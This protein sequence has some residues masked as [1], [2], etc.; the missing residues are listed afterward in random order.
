[1]SFHKVLGPALVALSLSGVRRLRGRGARRLRARDIPALLGREDVLVL[2]TE[3]T[4]VGRNA[5]VIEVVAIDTTGALRFEALSFPFGPISRG[6]QE[7]HGLSA[8]ALHAMGARPWPEVHPALVP[9]LREAEHV[10]AWRAD[11]D[12]RVLEQTAAFH[13]LAQPP[14]QWADVRPAYVDARPGGRHSLADAM[15]REGLTWEGRHHRAEA[16]CR[17]VLA[18]MRTLARA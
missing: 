10:L 1:M 11:F 5:E 14:V 18:V 9:V 17:A 4:G 8:E 13:N 12:A 7:V 6:S 2:D 16:D 3:T 15:R